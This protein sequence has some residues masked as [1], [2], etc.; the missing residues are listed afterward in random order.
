MVAVAIPVYFIANAY[1]ERGIPI[2][3]A[4]TGLERTETSTATRSAQLPPNWTKTPTGTPTPTITP[5]P[6]ATP[7]PTALTLDFSDA[8]ISEVVHIVENGPK[9]LVKIV[10]PGGVEG[11]FHAVVEIVLQSWDY[12]CITTEE[13]DDHLFCVGGRLP[14][15]NQ[16]VL[17]VF[18]VLDEDDDSILVYETLFEVPPYIPATATRTPKSGGGPPPPP[19]NT[20]TPTPTPTITNT[21][22][23]TLTPTNTATAS[24]TPT[25]TVTPSITPTFT[26]VPPWAS[27]TPE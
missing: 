16:A 14:E 18:Q 1:R 8:F 26:D 11:D 24:L 3:I 10:V 5:T 13:S 27:A 9:T 23:P 19:Q 20:A 15:T 6:S 17:Q 21:P 25:A 12:T 22:S 7:T 4:L 2:A